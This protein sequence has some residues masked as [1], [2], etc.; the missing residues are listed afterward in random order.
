M[1]MSA[2]GFRESL[3]RYKPRVFVDGHAVASVP[4]ETR[5]ITRNRQPGRCC[6]AGC[7]VPEAP[8]MARLPARGKA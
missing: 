7:A 5:Q 2:A 6:A 4:D 8:Q 3:R 1:L